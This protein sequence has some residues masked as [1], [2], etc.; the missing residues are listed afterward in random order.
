[1][2]G[3]SALTA[4]VIVALVASVVALGAWSL[5]LKLR[6]Q[7]LHHELTEA[8]NQLARIQKL[9]SLGEMAG[10]FAHAF[11]D[12][13]TPIIGRTQ[14]LT[15]RLTDPQLREWVATIER[16]ALGGAQT[17]KRIQEF[18]R[19]RREETLVPVDLG[20]VL[21]Q[22][23]A[24]TGPRHRP[25]VRIE[26]DFEPV[27]SISGDPLGLREAFGHLI[28][29][30]IDSVPETGSVVVA[31][32]VEDGQ[33][34]V[35]VT[36]NGSGMSADTQARVFEPFFTT[37]PGATGLGLCLAHGI[38]ARHGGQIEIEST[39]GRGTTVRVSFPSE[40]LARAKPAAAR[41]AAAVVGGPARCLVV[42]DDTQVRDM[43]R[44]ILSNAGH[45]VVVAI[46]GSDGVERF[47]ADPSFD[48]IITDL[49][50]PKLNGLQLARVCKTLRPNIPVVM[51]T[52]WGV[53]LT[54]EEL[55]E[56]GVDEVLSKPVRMD[57]V[58]STIAT[59]RQRAA[60]A[61]A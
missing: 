15:Q 9:G 2:G 24:T 39:V 45:K 54:E 58:I 52:G 35:S 34:V 18:M 28:V 3:S 6:A 48:V 50:M 57:Q 17:V 20:V 55:S 19:M 46:D 47:K 36:D 56:H 13:L 1:L 14:L 5:W 21:Q 16:S 49:A 33:A 43:I 37:K 40:G 27:P 51:L 60:G 22:A 41:P 29:N 59:V 30:A 12:V 8:L 42:D 23:L 53:L 25:A 32:R 61:Q 26:A 44:D 4:S 31:T 10:S 38:V 7:R 11:N